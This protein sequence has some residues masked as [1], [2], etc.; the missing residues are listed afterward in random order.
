MHVVQRKLA[1]AK[2]EDGDSS[3]PSPQTSRA[4]CAYPPENPLPRYAASNHRAYAA[5][6]GYRYRLEQ[7]Q[8]A[9]ERPPAWGKV[10][11]LQQVL[12][13]EPNVDWWLWF[14]CDTFFMNMSVTV[15][16][17]LYRY[18]SAPGG[19]DAS[20]HL[21][22][23]EDAA[24]L[25]TGAFLLRRSDW[26]RSFLRRVW[27]KQDSIWISHP[28]WENAAMIWDLLRFN[29]EKFRYD[30]R[31]DVYPKEV[32]ILPQFEFNSYHPA[33]AQTLHDTWMPGKF[34]LAFNGV[35]SNTSPGVVQAL[36]GYYYELACELNRI[37]VVPVGREP[38]DEGE[39]LRRQ[40]PLPWLQGAGYYASPAA[41]G[42]EHRALAT[43]QSRRDTDLL[44]VAVT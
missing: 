26:S 2:A 3:Q 40:E 10:R 43:Q 34:V 35:L 7:R 12:E 6:H 17:L 32:R 18:A 8:L 42:R 1:D 39:C 15:D 20:I 27:G 33:T 16:S 44:K 29:S 24:M 19:L 23:A 22:A 5:R 4:V 28:W 13:E 14:D 37:P 41:Y 31:P 38:A 30:L 9:P 25:N 21:L 11:L 36:Y